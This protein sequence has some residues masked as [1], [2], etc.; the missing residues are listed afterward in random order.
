MKDVFATHHKGKGAQR[1]NQRFREMYGKEI[2][3]IFVTA[4]VIIKTINSE[5]VVFHASADG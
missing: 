4:F 1:F 5:V 3:A 2:D